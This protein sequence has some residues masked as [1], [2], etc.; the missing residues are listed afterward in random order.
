MEKSSPRSWIKPIVQLFTIGII[1]L[2]MLGYISTLKVSADVP[3][4]SIDDVSITEGDSGTSSMIFTVFLTGVYTTG[5]TVDY[6]MVAGTATAPSDYTNTNGTLIFTPPATSQTI[7]VP[8]VGDLVNEPTE[9]FTVRLSN[10]A[11]AAIVKSDGIGTIYDNDPLPTLSIDNP[12]ITEGD[13][14]TSPMNFT[15]T[16]AGATEQTV[17]VA[18][19]TVAGTAT[20]PSD[21]TN[22]SGTLTFTPPATSQTISVPI[23]G[24]LVNEPTESFILRLSNPTNAT[25]VKSDGIGTIYDND[26]LPTLSI[27]NPS[28]TEGDSGTSPMNFTVTLAGAT[29]QTVTVAYA[30]VAGTATAPSDY[31]NTSGTLTFNPSVT[32]RTISVPIVG[33]LVNEPTE[34]F[35]LRLSNPTN[36]TILKSDGIGTI[37]DNDPLPTLSIDNPSI[38]EG[39]SGTS[40]MNFT[41]TLAGATARTVSVAYATADNTATA[42][43]D[44]TNTSGTLTFTPPATSHTISV[45]IVGDVVHES[46]ETFSVHLSNPTNATIVKSDG[47]GTIYDNDPFPALSINDPSIAEGDSGTSL[48]NFTVTL[49]GVTAQTVT[50]A[51]A[52][53]DN[54]A[55]APSDYTNTS[56]TLTFTPTTTSRTISIPIVG[57]L[58]HEP[59]EAFWVRMSNPTN[60][61]IAK[62]DGIGTI[63]DND[64]PPTIAFSQNTPY[65]VFETD[66]SG[67]AV[68]P[69]ILSAA[70]AY[71]VTVNYAT[72]D[73]TAHQGINYQAT[74]G[75][76]TFPAGSTSQSIIVPILNDH[77]NN[78][79]LNLTIN[80]SVAV[81]GTLGSPS[82][83]T[84]AIL[85][86]DPQPTLFI[87]NVSQ[88]EG[89]VG[90][91]NFNFTV[92]LSPASGN[93][94]TVDYAVVDGTAIA[95]SDYISTSGTL[96]FKPGDVSKTITVLVIGDDVKEANETFSVHL[97]DP[98][99]ASL[100]LDTGIGTI[101][102]DDLNQ[103]LLPLFL[104]SGKPDLIVAG[105][106]LTPSKSSYH[107]SDPVL[108]TVQVKNS[109]STDAGPF[110]V[111]FYINPQLPPTSSNVP[112]NTVCGMNPCYGI[113]WEVK[114]GLRVG[115]TITLT[116]TAD[117]YS[118][119]YTN[120]KGSLPTG[121]TDL[122]VYVD[123]WAGY[124]NPNGAVNEINETNNRGEIHGLKV[125]P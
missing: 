46:T 38:I 115:Q 30:T 106:T 58:V 73:G 119:G 33:D 116:S 85:D 113:A 18:Y 19:A 90:T 43:S 34:S 79:T 92:S 9:S 109:G 23:V 69:V 97:S 44:Y 49:T 100:A 51:Y 35:T 84:L 94:V 80:L 22:T 29:A 10:P 104:I 76:L 48:M 70:S 59:T 45:P 67:Q 20:A 105:F 118:S 64:P 47:I 99:N 112:W 63:Y 54:T 25:I 121:A 42:P 2:L 52:T 98:V 12:S 3:T 78:P 15:V 5:V 8:I 26:P 11:N 81:N 89:D 53:A 108:V 77:Q 117:S 14:G 75:T 123:S 39:D 32:S 62:S 57:D 6:S 16:L 36:A 88:N 50:V 102:D 91:T 103:A 125:T 4:L 96:T 13:S 110:W 83:A 107:A 60:A 120:W 41:V 17:T 101:L 87:N 37:Y 68:I 21:Y 82:S 95:G 27:D 7:S 61:N 111:D 86:Q 114:G 93:I 24:D 71:P 66:P 56:G 124:N 40:L 55:T 122:Y 74:N 65:T 31:T 28:I 1:L 72:S